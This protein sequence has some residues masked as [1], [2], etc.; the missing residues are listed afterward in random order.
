MGAYEK[1]H[2][3]GGGRSA[4]TEHKVNLGNI[5]ITERSDGSDEENYLHK[6]HLGSTISVTDK[7]GSVVQQFTYDPWGKQTKIYQASPLSSLVYFQPTTRGYTGHE[8]IDGLDIVHMNGRIYDANI[9]R[10]MKADPHIQSP[11]NFQN[12]N[13]YSYVLNNPLSYTDPSGFFFK[14]LFKA[15]KKYWRTIASIVIAVYLPGASFLTGWST[16]ATGAFVGFVSGAVATGSLRGALTGALTG[17]M[18]GGLHGMEAGAGKVVMH[19]LS[20][21][22]GSVLNGGKFGHG[23]FSAGFTQFASMK[24]WM[25]KIGANTASQRIKNA[26]AAAVVGGT[27]SRLTGGKFASGAITGAFSRLLNDMAAE[28]P[29]WESVSDKEILEVKDVKGELSIQAAGHKLVG[30]DT[31]GNVSGP[32]VAAENASISRD[33]VSIGGAKGPV[34][35]SADSDGNIKI[36]ATGCT[37]GNSGGC[38][39]AEGVVKSPVLETAGKNVYKALTPNRHLPTGKN[40]SFLERWLGK[41]DMGDRIGN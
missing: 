41:L 9:G 8:M 23:F 17:A 27:M 35:V 3:T 24:G 18:F 30:V 33:G 6:D 36:S 20:G 26:L 10:F 32:Q 11:G 15:V 19:G 28:E 7:T 4:L 16:A 2:R 25:P 38:I 12:Y 13:R 40:S 31:E 34:G 5:V 22:I 29:R 39:T 1:I 14:K 21:G 37:H